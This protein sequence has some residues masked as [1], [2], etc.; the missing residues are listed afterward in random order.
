MRILT[1]QDAGPMCA[2]DFSKCKAPKRLP[3]ET[4]VSQ[5]FN[6]SQVHIQ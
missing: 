6:V 4:D 2:S 3:L 5:T 1:E